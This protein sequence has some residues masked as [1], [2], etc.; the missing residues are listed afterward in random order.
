LVVILRGTPL[1][2]CSS[3]C[4]SCL[5]LRSR[6]RKSFRLSYLSYLSCSTVQMAAALA[7][8][9]IASLSVRL[10]VSS[11]ARLAV[12]LAV[13][14]AVSL[15]VRV[16]ACLTVHMVAAVALLI[17]S[18]WHRL[19]SGS[20]LSFRFYARRP[21]AARLLHVRSGPSSSVAV[22]EATGL[23]CF[24]SLLWQIPKECQ[25]C[26]S[27][28]LGASALLDYCIPAQVLL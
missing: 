17:R 11:A 25:V 26:N 20:L 21:S 24:R 10:A 28:L 14:L 19:L 3:C 7:L 1:G 6:Y 23:C 8:Q 9:L 5:V 15:A 22:M 13:L 12:G 16:R 27:S 4:F 2:S 18:F